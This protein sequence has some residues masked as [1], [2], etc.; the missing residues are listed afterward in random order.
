MSETMHQ[1]LPII[2]MYGFVSLLAPFIAAA[3]W[4]AFE[5]DRL[6][7]AA[8]QANLAAQAAATSAVDLDLHVEVGGRELRDADLAL[9][10]DGFALV[11]DAGTEA[12]LVG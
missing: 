12:A 10:A 8:A 6:N 7:A 1:A 9:Q 5:G 2:F 4:F 11:E 3:L